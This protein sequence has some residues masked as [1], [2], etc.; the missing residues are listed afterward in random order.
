MG[1]PSA[2]RYIEGG[3][4]RYPRSDAEKYNSASPPHGG[5]A[6]LTHEIKLTIIGKIIT[7]ITKIDHKFAQLGKKQYL[8]A[9][10][11]R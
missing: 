9:P 10:K 8:C 1:R 11:G 4:R 7:F 6:E 2:T 3:E 5:L